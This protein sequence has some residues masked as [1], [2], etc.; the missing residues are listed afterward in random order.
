[1]TVPAWIY[2][3]AAA[4]A[5]LTVVGSMPFWKKWCA[6][7]GLVDDPGHR[8][9]HE[10]TVPL[11]GGLAVMTGLMVPTAIAALLL[12]WQTSAQPP[13]APPP[14]PHPDAAQVS[15]LNATTAALLEHGFH[16]RYV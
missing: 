3:L 11:A 1:M 13:A 7:A 12:W 8:K 14:Q 15:P 2:L 4:G 16:K 6:R 9:L 5:F 10:G